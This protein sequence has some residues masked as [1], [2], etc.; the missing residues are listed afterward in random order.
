V[1]GGALVGAGLG[2]AAGAVWG[3]GDFCGGI[4]ARRAPAGAVLALAASSGA[5]LLLALALAAGEAVPA[6]DDLGWSVAAGLAGALGIGA[7]YAAL[8]I[9][10]AAVVAP[11]T[12]VT[13]ALVPVTFGLLAL[14][15]PGA[16]LLAGFALA[17]AG[18]AFVTRARDATGTRTLRGLPLAVLSGASLGAFLVLMAQV[19]ASAVYAPL[20]VARLIMLGAGI[21]FAV[22]TRALPRGRAGLGIA[23]LAGILDAGGNTLYL[24]AT[25]FTRVDVAAVLTSLYP[26][27]TVL[28]SR[29]VLRDPV[30]GP[31]WIGVGVCLA[32]VALI[33][34]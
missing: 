14:D 3:A 13:G 33:A 29:A 8:A 23:L 25:H 30:S 20:L 4:A 28:L 31:Q 17:L 10:S 34:S 26:A 9:G 24:L 22:A 19:D 11:T 27:S 6:R 2:L 21:A 1:I 15:P 16:S 5:V 32:A 12:A 18:V 7:L